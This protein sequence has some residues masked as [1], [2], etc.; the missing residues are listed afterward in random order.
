METPQERR[1]DHLTQEQA[2]ATAHNIGV[3]SPG[4]IRGI[5]PDHGEPVLFTPGELLPAWVVAALDGGKGHYEATTGV[6]VL[7]EPKKGGHK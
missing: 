4:F 6:F 5:H 7:D 1:A 3:Q 2:G